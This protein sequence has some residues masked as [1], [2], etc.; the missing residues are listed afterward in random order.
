MT[1]K[2]RVIREV[3]HDKFEEEIDNFLHEIHYCKIIKVYSSNTN[4]YYFF[5]LYDDGKHQHE[6]EEH[7]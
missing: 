3:A 1:R 4:D 5:C 6:Q 2:A 7:E